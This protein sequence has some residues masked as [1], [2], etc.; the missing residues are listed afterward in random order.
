M[1]FGHSSDI[2]E[3]TPSIFAGLDKLSQARIF[4]TLYNAS[5]E[6]DLAIPLSYAKFLNIKD[7]FNARI[8]T[9]LKPKFLNSK[10]ANSLCLASNAI[11]SAYLKNE[12]SSLKFIAKQ[13]KHVAAKMIKMLY[14]KGEFEICLD[15]NDMFS[16]FVYDKIAAKHHDKEVAFENGI[17]SIR[18]GGREL[19]SVMPSFKYVNLDDMRNLSDEINRAVG[20]LNSKNHE[21]IYIIFPRNK[22][23]KHHVEVRHCGCMQGSLKLVPYTIS[24]KIF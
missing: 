4:I 12:F 9:L 15:A 23:F 16:Q 10:C 19:L 22:E 21:R 1:K 24:N 13:P 2:G 18:Q 11:I 7:I 6:R 8:N 5:V 14:A 3:I 17:I 20:V